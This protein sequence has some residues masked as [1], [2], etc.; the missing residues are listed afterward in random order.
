M[1]DQLG[2]GLLLKRY[3]DKVIDATDVQIEKAAM[4]T[5][6]SVLPLFFSF[7]IM[8]GC[9]VTMLFIFITAFYLTARRVEHISPRFLKLA[10]F[11]LPLPWIASEAG[12][13][14]AEYG[15]QPW[16]IGGL[17]PTWMS[18]SSLTI[19]DLYMSIAGFTIFYGIFAVVEIYLMVKYARMGPSSLH[20]GRYHFE[21][22]SI[23]Q[24]ETPAMA[25]S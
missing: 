6:P 18:A 21:Q 7:R 1:R 14:V 5:V 16:S 19:T 8:V 12:W 24:E 17:L 10:L 4:D 9:G 3:T 20:T 11:A 15:R 2:Y 13:F 23:E 22:K 25:A